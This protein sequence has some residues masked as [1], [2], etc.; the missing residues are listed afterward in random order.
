MNNVSVKIN[1]ENDPFTPGRINLCE[2]ICSYVQPSVVSDKEGTD[3]KLGAEATGLLSLCLSFL[4]IEGDV[5]LL[6]PACSPDM[7]GKF[8]SKI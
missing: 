8:H 1:Y 2:N 7:H 5:F 4:F 3:V 6:L